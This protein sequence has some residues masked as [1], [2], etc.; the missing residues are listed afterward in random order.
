MAAALVRLAE[1]YSSLCSSLGAPQ[2]K[3]SAQETGAVDRFC[4]RR[5]LATAVEFWGLHT[6]KAGWKNVDSYCFSLPDEFA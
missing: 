1:P 3:A 6:V 5:T 4:K 2:D